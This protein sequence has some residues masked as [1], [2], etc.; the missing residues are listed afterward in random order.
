MP[1]VARTQPLPQH[2]FLSAFRSGPGASLSRSPA[3][4]IDTLL[5]ELGP[6]H[7]ADFAPTRGAR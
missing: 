5:K 7:L 3:N 6:E 4:G 1:D 2:G